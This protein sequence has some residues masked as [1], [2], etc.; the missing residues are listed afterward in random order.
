MTLLSKDKD[1]YKER[2]EF[3][4]QDFS[5]KSGKAMWKPSVFKTGWIKIGFLTGGT[6]QAHLMRWPDIWF[7]FTSDKLVTHI[8]IEQF[9]PQ[10]KPRHYEHVVLV[11]LTLRHV[12]NGG[13]KPKILDI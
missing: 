11:L 6:S 12:Y 3:S 1:P 7:L 8:T 2:S 4:F 5:P 10:K 13:A 9:L